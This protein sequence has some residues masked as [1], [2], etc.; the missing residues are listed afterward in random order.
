MPIIV[1][2]I[3]VL[4]LGLLMG[5]VAL[6]IGGGAHW[7]GRTAVSNVVA[8]EVHCLICCNLKWPL[9]FSP[10]SNLDLETII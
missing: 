9:G 4:A 6:T 8:Y 10:D 7:A 2:I 3:N 5:H 1:I